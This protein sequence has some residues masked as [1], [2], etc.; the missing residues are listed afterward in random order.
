[1]EWT[2]VLQLVM[3]RSN[4][5]PE[6]KV[7]DEEVVRDQPPAHRGALLPVQPSHPGCRDE[8]KLDE[9]VVYEH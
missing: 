8:Q 6:S 7:C 4:H 9:Y 1:M 5:A 2:Q 3:P